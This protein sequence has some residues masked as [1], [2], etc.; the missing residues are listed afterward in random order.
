[1]L[2]PALEQAGIRLLSMDDVTPDERAALDA[3]FETE[4]FPVLTP[5]AVDPG[6]P[7]PYISN[8]SISLAVELRDPARGG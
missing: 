8:L 1:M 4:V 7:F 3:Y 6:H 2:L 5:L